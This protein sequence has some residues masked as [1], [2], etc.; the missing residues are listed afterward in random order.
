MP[1]EL[2]GPDISQAEINAVTEVLRSGRLSLGPA[3]PRFEEVVA[4]YVGVKH[5]IAVS[6]GTCGLHLLV[7]AMEIGHGDEV[8]T[9]PFSF[10]ASSNAI[11]HAKLVEAVNAGIMAFK[12]TV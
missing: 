10:V 4:K 8:I 12:Q 2:S 9:T 3:V 6:S 7:R 5:A 1:I 11:L